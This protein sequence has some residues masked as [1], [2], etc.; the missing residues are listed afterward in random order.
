MKKTVII[1]SEEEGEKKEP[2]DLEPGAYTLSVKIKD[3][4]SGKSL[5]KEINFEVK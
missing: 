4:V 2:K 5:T 3:N 1:K